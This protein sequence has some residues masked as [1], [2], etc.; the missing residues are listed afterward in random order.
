MCKI[1][2]KGHMIIRY[3]LITVLVAFITLPYASIA[4]EETELQE[5]KRVNL[6]ATGVMKSK[7]TSRLGAIVPGIVEHVYVNVGD[8]VETGQ[9]LFKMRQ[10]DYEL[11]LRQA[12]AAVNLAYAKFKISK[13]KRKRAEE[14]F[15]KKNISESY[16]DEAVA[17][18]EI[19][20]ADLAVANARLDVAKQA[21]AD[22][23]FHAPYDGTITR[24]Q[25]NEGVY[26]T[27]QSFSD[28]GSILELQEDKIM[29]AIVFIPVRYVSD[30]HIGQTSIL[31]I[32]GLPKTIMAKITAI[33]HQAMVD[34]NMIELRIPVMNN[35]FI[36][37][38]GQRVTVHIQT[39]RKSM[40]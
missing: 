38:D 37:K 19:T 34:S 24:R 22:T 12:K 21:L 36:I 11:S 8:R 15:Q 32:D 40:K 23:V 27:V 35:K 9:P 5:G 14:L 18:F 25:V 39:L 13:K 1:I 20:E 17:T 28:N 4:R 10:R 26:K 6:I 30:I 7:R 2:Q 33:N 29:V 3:A 31:S 16:L